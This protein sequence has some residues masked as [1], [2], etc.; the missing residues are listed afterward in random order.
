MVSCSTQS[1]SA[2]ILGLHVHGYIVVNGKKSRLI[3]SLTAFLGQSSS[4]DVFIVLTL[5]NVAELI[6]VCIVEVRGN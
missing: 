2:T 1:I 5:Y 6:S 3:L 4:L